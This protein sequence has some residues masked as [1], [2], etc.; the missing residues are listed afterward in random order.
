MCEYSSDS[1]TEDMYTEWLRK[2]WYL[3]EWNQL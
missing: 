3:Y 2:G 1:G